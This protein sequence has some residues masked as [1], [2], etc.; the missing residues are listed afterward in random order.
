MMCRAAE[1]RDELAS[2]QL[3]ELR[4]GPRSQISRIPN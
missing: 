2:L 1:Q 3:L 4:F